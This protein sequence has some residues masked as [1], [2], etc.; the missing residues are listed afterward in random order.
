MNNKLILFL[1]LLFTCRIGTY[2]QEI[3]LVLEMDDKSTVSY[4]FS[5]KP[6]I[7]FTEQSLVIDTEKVSSEYAI[8]K[9]L[10]Y[11]FVEQESTDVENIEIAENEIRFTYLDNDNLLVEGVDDNTHLSVYDISGRRYNVDV[12]NNGNSIK[13]SLFQLPSGTYI[14][15]V[16]G[17]H[18][19]KIRKNR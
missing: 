19:I 4:S 14:V 17:E 7:T 1:L 6:V 3:L 13:V 2:A 8:G 11:Y 10:R 16:M 5:E 18:S 12:V 15:N 9:V